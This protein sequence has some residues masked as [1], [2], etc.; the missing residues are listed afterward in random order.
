MEARGKRRALGDATRRRVTFGLNLVVGDDAVD[1]AHAQRFVSAEDAPL[2]QD[3]ERLRAADQGDYAAQLGVGHDQAE[4]L[5]RHAERAG[6]AADAHI[7]ERRRLE[8][9][10]DAYPLDQCERRVAARLERA[11][12]ALDR[13]VVGARLVAVGALGLEL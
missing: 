11:D 6:L 10:A 7:A 9:A 12:R 13:R 5:D 2:E 3:F 1:Q 8:P 4:A